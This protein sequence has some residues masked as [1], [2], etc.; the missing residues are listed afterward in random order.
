MR[1]TQGPKSCSGSPAGLQHSVLSYTT[2]TTVPTDEET[3]NRFAIT[4]QAILWTR[5]TGRQERREDSGVWMHGTGMVR[6]KASDGT[7]FRVCDFLIFFALFRPTI[8]WRV[9][10]ALFGSQNAEVQQ[11]VQ[12]ARNFQPAKSFA[13]HQQA[14]GLIRKSGLGTQKP[15]LT[16]NY[17]PRRHR[18]NLS[19]RR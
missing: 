13:P 14:K 5:T 17:T 3:E 12:K 6:G 2:T 19:N 10:R 16:S 1:E 9:I 18:N 11:V 4:A 7:A 15:Q 8:C